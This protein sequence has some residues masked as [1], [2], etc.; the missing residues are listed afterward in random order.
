MKGEGMYVLYYRIAEFGYISNLGTC[1]SNPMLFVHATRPFR[2]AGCSFLT[3]R[4]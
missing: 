3:D 2:H 1:Y 4:I